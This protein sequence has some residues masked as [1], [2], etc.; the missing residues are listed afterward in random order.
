MQ[1]TAYQNVCKINHP[2]MKD[3]FECNYYD[4]NN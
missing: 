3:P 4:D 2:A 1:I